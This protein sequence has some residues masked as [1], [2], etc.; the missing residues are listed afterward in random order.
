MRRIVFEGRKKVTIE[1]DSNHAR[2]ACRRLDR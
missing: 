2:F 1:N